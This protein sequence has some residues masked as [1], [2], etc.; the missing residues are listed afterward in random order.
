MEGPGDQGGPPPPPGA[1]ASVQPLEA[2]SRSG[3]CAYSA[4]ASLQWAV[5]VP[6][7][8]TE[9]LSILVSGFNPTSPHLTA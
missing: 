2:D 8:V 3:S 1:A 5:R 9:G 7:G 6:S 4:L